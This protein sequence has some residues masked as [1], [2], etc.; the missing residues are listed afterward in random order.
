ML[1]LWTGL[2]TRWVTK[3]CGPVEF[4]HAS[5][6]AATAALYAPLLLGAVSHCTQQMPALLLLL[7]FGV[8]VCCKHGWHVYLGCIVFAL[9]DCCST[10]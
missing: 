4:I 10:L 2:N 3:A 6:T 8:S 5:H 9:Q 1:A 7:L